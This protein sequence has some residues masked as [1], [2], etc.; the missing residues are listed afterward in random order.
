MERPPRS[1]LPSRELPGLVTSD[2]D[3]LDMGHARAAVV[4]VRGGHHQVIV[5]HGEGLAIQ[6]VWWWQLLLP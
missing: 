5:Q 4:A 1:G 2:D 3:A 6:R